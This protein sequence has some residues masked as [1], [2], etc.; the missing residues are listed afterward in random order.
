MIIW[1]SKVQEKTISTGQF[2]CPH[3]E[4]MTSYKLVQSDKYFTLYFIP[5]FVTEHIGTHVNCLNCR[6][7]YKRRVLELVPKTEEE[8]LIGIFESDIASGTPKQ[9]AVRKAVAGGVESAEAE[10][11]ATIALGDSARHCG[12]CQFDFKSNVQECTACG[13]MLEMA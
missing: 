8:R 9:I 2:L 10:R 4:A 1:G 11:L 6:Q 5:L 7:Y 3:C 13:S 12:S